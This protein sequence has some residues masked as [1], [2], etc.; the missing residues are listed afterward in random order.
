MDAVMLFFG[1]FL[2]MEVGEQLLRLI[3]ACFCGTAIG[4]ERTKRYKEAGIRTHVI[5]CCASAL[6]MIVS[7]Y[8]FSDLTAGVDGIKAAKGEWDKSKEYM[9]PQINALV[10]RYS[11]LDDEA[12]H[13][14]YLPVDVTIR[15]ALDH[16]G[17][18]E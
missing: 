17:V 14:F 11:K 5:V 9:M 7:K 1:S 8:G 4:L 3:I 15:T 2:S 10:G 16:D 18:L 12:F 13:R 6:L